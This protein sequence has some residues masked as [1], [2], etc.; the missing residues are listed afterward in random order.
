[1][2]KLQRA[3][4][5]GEPGGLGLRNAPRSPKQ[6]KEERT[7]LGFLGWFRFQFDKQRMN[8]AAVLHG[9]LSI[10][11]HTSPRTRLLAASV[12]LPMSERGVDG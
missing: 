1:V 4:R 5:D 10:R 8:F 9:A 7:G 12:R 3:G 2:G 6:K 11:D